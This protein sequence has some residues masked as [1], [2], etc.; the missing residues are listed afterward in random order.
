MRLVVGGGIDEIL[1]VETELE[2][3]SMEKREENETNNKIFS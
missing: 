3:V 1:R 2:K